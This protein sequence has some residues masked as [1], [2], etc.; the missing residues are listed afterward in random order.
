MPAET[1][2]TAII[3]VED[4]AEEQP[5][6]TAVSLDVRWLHRKAYPAGA[7]NRLAET[8]LQAL[9]GID[10]ETFVWVACEREDI[11]L[12]RAVLKSRRHDRKRM[13][14]AWYWERNGA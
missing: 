7:R 8:A 12:I 10:G 6:S 1:R 4:A 9:E 3:E 14:V 5:L 2:L 11:R 13:Y